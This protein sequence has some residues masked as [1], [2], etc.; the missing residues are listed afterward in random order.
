MLSLI[1]FYLYTT[2]PNYYIHLAPAA[3][4]QDAKIPRVLPQYN[5][6]IS[7]LVLST[8][9]LVTIRRVII[10]EAATMNG[11]DS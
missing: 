3:G 5:S 7:R 1:S 9:F 2:T 10:Y 11:F 8:A 6:L 4:H